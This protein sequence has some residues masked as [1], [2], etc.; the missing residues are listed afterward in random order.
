MCFSYS[1]HFSVSLKSFLNKKLPLKSYYYSSYLRGKPADFSYGKCVSLPASSPIQSED[2]PQTARQAPGHL[3]HSLV[4]D[5]ACSLACPCGA[6]G[7][8]EFPSSRPSLW[9]LLNMGLCVTQG[10]SVRLG[11]IQEGMVSGM[12]CEEGACGNPLMAISGPVD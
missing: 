7:R 2:Q 8:A 4:K 9:P 6:C 12:L 11:Q 10:A 1:C 3:L 5:G